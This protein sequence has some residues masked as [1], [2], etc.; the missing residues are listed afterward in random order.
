MNV[1]LWNENY[2][3]HKPSEICTSALSYFALV[4]L[5]TDTN[6]LRPQ[7]N[8]PS[9]IHTPLRH[10]TSP[11]DDTTWTMGPL[12][13]I[14]YVVLSAKTYTFLYSFFYVTAWEVI[15]PRV[16]VSRRR[17]MPIAFDGPSRLGALATKLRTSRSSC[18]ERVIGT[19]CCRSVAYRSKLCQFKRITFIYIYITIYTHM[20]HV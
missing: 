17:P 6:G 13:I 9:L 5:T 7:E 14:N 16:A 12:Q 8:Y 20:N 1:V 15:A 18:A 10:L 4:L 11:Y 2:G 19:Y 3:N